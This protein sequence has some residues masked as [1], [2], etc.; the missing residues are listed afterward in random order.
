MLEEC[1]RV[2]T[3]DVWF[4]DVAKLESDRIF[5]SEVVSLPGAAAWPVVL[6]KLFLRPKFVL[7]R[8]DAG[9]FVRSS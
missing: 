5:L 3:N 4:L 7:F 6:I 2:D 9:A 8:K 1:C